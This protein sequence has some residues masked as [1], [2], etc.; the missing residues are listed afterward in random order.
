ME[1]GN[2]GL[3]QEN[4]SQVFL[5]YSVR[6]GSNFISSR[7]FF[8][9][10]TQ[11]INKLTVMNDNNMFETLFHNLGSTHQYG[12]QFTG[13]WAIGKSLSLQP[14]FK[15]FELHTLPNEFAMDHGMVNKQ[16]L[17]F[18]SGL[19]AILTLKNNLTAT[20]RYQYNSPRAYMQSSTYSDALYFLSVEKTI[21][22]N[23][24]V[25]LT[26]GIPFNRSFTY[27]GKDVEGS[28]F[29]S[30]WEGTIKTSGF[31]V[32]LK[33]SY[34]FNSGKKLSKIRRNTENIEQ[35]PKKGF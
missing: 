31:P 26:S 23:L 19:S 1:N 13:A 11:T 14:Y 12:I 10:T 24:K 5:D 18:E 34:R 20:L 21:Y 6:P 22:E 2:P 30:T 9:K 28:D 17:E 15:L 25:G 35:I 27:Y 32:W 3:K 16:E 7:I 4:R 29:S 8:Q 33:I